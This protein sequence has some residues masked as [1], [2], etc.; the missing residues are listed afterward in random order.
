MMKRSPNLTFLGYMRLPPK[1]GKVPGIEKFDANFFGVPDRQANEMDPQFKIC[2]ETTF[3]AIIDAGMDPTDLR[4]SRTG[5]YI[6]YC[7]ADARQAQQQIDATINETQWGEDF[8]EVSK[9]FGFKG[10]CMTYDSA[11]ASSFS[12]FNEAFHA[13]KSNVIDTAIVAGVAICTSPLAATGFRQ[14]GMTSEE[15]RSR[16]MDKDA[17]GYVRY[18]YILFNVWAI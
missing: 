8:S 10:P 18:A 5:M 17:N 6:G 15:G 7:Y 16:C 14:L 11:C 13:I 1:A 4:S 9:Y 12:A 3:E 2:H